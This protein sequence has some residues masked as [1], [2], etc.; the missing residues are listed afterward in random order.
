MLQSNIAELE[1]V[2]WAVVL[3]TAGSF[4][5]LRRH[6]TAQ[7]VA[8]A[9]RLELEDDAKVAAT[10]AEAA[11]QRRAAEAKAAR[12]D[13]EVQACA[14]AARAE[15]EAEAKAEAAA[16]AERVKARAKA[17]AEADEKARLEAIAQARTAMAAEA[18]A[19]AA[20]SAVAAEADAIRVRLAELGADA[21]AVAPAAPVGRAPKRNSITE[22]EAARA[23]KMRELHRRAS[24]DFEARDNGADAVVL[25][26][27]RTPSRAVD[28]A[29]Q[30]ARS[31]LASRRMPTREVDGAD[32][33]CAARRAELVVISGHGDGLYPLVFTRIGGKTT[34]VGDF[35]TLESLNEC[36]SLPPDVLA[37]NPQIATF[38]K[39][40]ARF[41]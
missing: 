11:E 35:E 10:E 16:E 26:V 24:I 20:R 18:E 30:A 33:A 9:A 2:L 14:D 6:W 19:E 41:L 37:E 8:A 23:E 4:V 1:G 7:A 28:A 29:Q 13:T 40:F 31:I 22:L 15:A 12:L 5:L 21:D 39:A 17:R 3:C 36:D 34:F 27:T 32:T 25:L 38:S